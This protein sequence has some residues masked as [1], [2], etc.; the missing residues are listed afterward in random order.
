MKKTLTLITITLL[1][2]TSCSSTDDKE[3]TLADIVTTTTQLPAPPTPTTSIQPDGDTDWAPANDTEFELVF[4][5]A[6]DGLTPSEQY[7]LCRSYRLMGED[8]V[9]S[10]LA[11]GIS[12]TQSQ[13]DIVSEFLQENC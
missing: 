11:D 6:W 10:I 4:N 3:N 13:E 8:W 5:L 9:I 12:M 2:L 7:G 1:L